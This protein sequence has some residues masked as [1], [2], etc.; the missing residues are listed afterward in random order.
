MEA[1]IIL[2]MIEA[3]DPADTAKLDEIDSR[4]D[5][6]V[7]RLTFVA[8]E[9]SSFGGLSYKYKCDDPPPKTQYG[10]AWAVAVPRYTRSRDALKAIRPEGWWF[11]IENYGDTEAMCTATMKNRNL[12]I[13]LDS[14]E[15]PTEE[16]AEL[17]AIIQAI[18]YERGEQ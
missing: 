18:A 3:V 11:D 15:L 9:A 12:D 5:A 13:V 16:L 4:A 2:D 7:R 8:H 14:D 1:Q 17:H 10:C 6:Y